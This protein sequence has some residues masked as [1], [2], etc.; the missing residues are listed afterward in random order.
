[1]EPENS[2]KENK[3]LFSKRV[4]FIF[5]LKCKKFYFYFCVYVCMCVWAE[6]WLG[7]KQTQ[8]NI[9][10]LQESSKNVHTVNW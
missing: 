8:I 9:T 2:Y 5:A 10:K 6:G 1:M 7:V 3:K 4:Y